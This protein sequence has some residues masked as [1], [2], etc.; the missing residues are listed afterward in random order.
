[1]TADRAVF[2][3]QKKEAEER[4]N[5]IESNREEGRETGAFFLASPHCD[6]YIASVPFRK[7]QARERGGF[8]LQ[9]LI[10][11]ARTIDNVN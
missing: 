4:Q 10:D 11:K 6:S 9:I 8:V 5:K 2:C 1:M 3:L 7:G